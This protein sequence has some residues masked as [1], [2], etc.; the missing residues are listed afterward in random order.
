MKLGFIPSR[1][2]A[3][4]PQGRYFSFEDIELKGQATFIEI[5]NDAAARVSGSA[6]AVLGCRSIEANSGQRLVQCEVDK[7]QVLVYDLDRLFV[8]G[9]SPAEHQLIARVLNVIAK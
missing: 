6:S 7:R 2:N 8:V 3:N 1:E 9:I 4:L 5:D